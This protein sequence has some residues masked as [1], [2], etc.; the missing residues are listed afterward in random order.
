MS[1]VCAFHVNGLT[2]YAIHKKLELIIFF[3]IKFHF[4]EMEL[5]SGMSNFDWARSTEVLSI[6]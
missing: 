4:F 5:I 1:S 6:L 2:H 3:P